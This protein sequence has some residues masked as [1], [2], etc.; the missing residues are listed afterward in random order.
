MPLVDLGL[1]VAADDAAWAWG[2]RRRTMYWSAS[3]ETSAA[4]RLSRMRTSGLPP[5]IRVRV[6]ASSSK[7]WIRS[8]A[9]FSSRGD[10][11]AGVAADGRA[12]LADLGEL[13]KEGD[14]GPAAR[15]EKS[16]R[17]DGAA[18]VA[19][20]EVVLDQLAEALVRERPVLLD[21]APVEDADLPDRRRGSSAPRAGASCRFRA[22]RPRPRT[23]PRRR[24]RRSGVAGARRTPSRGRR[25][26]R[27]RAAG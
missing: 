11:D 22:R 1:P 13:G 8:S 23:G 14:A 17:S 12:Q 16:G 19:G 26:R 15:S 3:I 27:P 9:F 10:R 2:R 7:T 21:E 5:A 25:R 24:S 18:G 4:C 6:R 20:L